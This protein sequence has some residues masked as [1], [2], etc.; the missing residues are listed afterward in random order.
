MCGLRSEEVF[1]RQKV[2]GVSASVHRRMSYLMYSLWTWALQATVHALRPIKSKQ[3][4][5]APSRSLAGDH[6][7]VCTSWPL[8]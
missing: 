4:N 2:L 7:T 8:F 6:M 1:V 3:N 5:S